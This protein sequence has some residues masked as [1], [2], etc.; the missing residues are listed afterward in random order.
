MQTASLW[1]KNSTIAKVNRNEAVALD[2]NFITIFNKAQEI[3]KLT[4]GAFDITVGLLVNA[5]GIGYKQNVE[6][7]QKTI[8]SMLNFVGY[9]NIAIKDGFFWKKYPEISIDFNAIAKGYSVDL[10][11]NYLKGN[12]ITDYLVD[13][14]GE[15]RAEGENIDTKKKWL[16]GIERPSKTANDER[17]YQ[18][19][20]QL[21]GKSIATSGTYRK[22]REVDG[23]RYSHTI[24]PKTGYPVS[25]TLLS[26]TVIADDCITAD[27]LAT[28]FMVMGTEKAKSVLAKFKDCEALFIV[29]DK[30]GNISA[31]NTQGFLKYFYEE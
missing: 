19:V 22:Y 29:S 12:G 20:I 7:S 26:A 4:D 18:F 8:D 23:I 10:I 21:D 28:A 6:L 24:D 11:A 5:W 13:I 17:E 30:N 9:H 31:F 15:V 2:S 16:I 14:G 27:A 3:S 25:H 1:E